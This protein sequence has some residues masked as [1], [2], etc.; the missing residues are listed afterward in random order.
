MAT[1]R[2]PRESRDIDHMRVF[3]RILLLVFPPQSSLLL[4]G[5]QPGSQRF[6]RQKE[7]AL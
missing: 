1:S 3:A 2:T 5:L 7:I 6:E 4:P